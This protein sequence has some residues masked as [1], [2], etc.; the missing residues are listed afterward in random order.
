MNS[1]NRTLLLCR[2]GDSMKV[3]SKSAKESLKV[4]SVIETD[5][6]CTENLPLAEK[7]LLSDNQVIIAHGHVVVEEDDHVILFLTDPSKISLVEKLFL[8]GG[9]STK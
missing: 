9:S 2:C 4:S 6:L 5:L 1:Q 3:D 7:E 8:V